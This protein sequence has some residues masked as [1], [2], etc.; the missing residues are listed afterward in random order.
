MRVSAS[1]AFARPIHAPHLLEIIEL[2]HFRAEDVDDDIAP[3][4]QD[5]I[6]ARQSFDTRHMRGSRLKRLDHPI[7]DRCDMHV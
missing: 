2:P 1:E 6:G 5:P 3:I 4:D 7:G